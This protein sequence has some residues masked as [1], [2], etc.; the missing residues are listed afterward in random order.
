MFTE[1]EIINKM[2]SASGLAPVADMNTQH[3]SYKKALLKLTDVNRAVQLQG[4]WFNQSVQTLQPTI[5]GMVYV[6]NQ[7]L[8]C[9]P[10][11]DESAHLSARGSRIYDTTNRTYIIGTS[12][13]VE[14]VE[15]LPIL[16]LP[17]AVAEYVAARAVHEFYL[18]Q[19]GQDPK[20]SEYRG[21][22][23]LA[24]TEFKKAVLKNSRITQPTY[25]RL[26]S[27]YPLRRLPT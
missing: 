26:T 5:D 11:D 10:V 24:E 14:L 27:G 17:P 8:H 9:R 19:G 2:L 22:R 20:L 16:D 23:S 13:Q 25:A 3:P 7:A 4:Y 6:P 1:L 12:V 21:M 18:D 15:L